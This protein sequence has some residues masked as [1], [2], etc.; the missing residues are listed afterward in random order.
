MFQ[1]V[2][3]GGPAAVAGAR[4]TDVLLRIDDDEIVPPKEPAFRMGHT[5]TMRV[6][7]S[8][9]SRETLNFQVNVP[10]PKYPKYPYA[11]S[12]SVIATKINAAT[13][14]LKV[15]KFPG[16]IGVDFAHEV[17]GGFR[18]LRGSQRL[19]LDLRGNPGGGIGGLR[20]MSY[21]TPGRL[22]VG[23]SLTRY[24]A[25][26]GYSRES[27]PRL[28]RI[29]GQ[30]WMLPFLALRFVGRD[31]S[32]V[33]V[34]EGLGQQT[35]HGRTVI[36]VNE[37]TAGSGEMVA[38]FAKENGLA[39]IVGMKT[40]GRLLGAEGFSVDGGYVLALPIASYLSWNGHRFEG[41]GVTPEMVVDWDPKSVSDGTDN[42]LKT[43]LE[44][45]SKL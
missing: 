22:P 16:I 44:V 6:L 37:H 11:D 1:D 15:T 43:A 33:V 9:G 34:T 40:A 28:N 2:Q 12:R 23:Y 38:G 7:R 13:G 19:I 21:L 8:D 36:L 3:P 35:F 10:P 26:H 45:V 18:E 30:K 41:N 17:D 20:L 29:P 42:Q 27:L 24:R 25:E 14:L 32:I 4:P 5:A 31:Q 39:K